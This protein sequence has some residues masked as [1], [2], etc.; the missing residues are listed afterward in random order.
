[1]LVLG[2]VT[3]GVMLADVPSVH[4]VCDD[5]SKPLQA[6]LKFQN[7]P[8]NATFDGTKP[9]NV[10][11]Q[12]SNCSGGP[13][14]TTQGFSSTDFFRRLYATGPSGSSIINK[15]EET[16]HID[17]LSNF[18][19]LS[20]QG[21]L[22]SPSIAVVPVET[23]AGPPSPFFRQYLIDLRTFYDLSVPGHYSVKAQFDALSFD[24]NS[25]AYFSDCDQFPGTTLVT[26]ADVTGRNAFTVVSNTLEFLI[27][28]QLDHLVLTPAISAIASGGSEFYTA[29]GFDAQNHSLGDLT[30]STTFTIAPEGTC[31]GQTCTATA[32]GPHT[33]TGTN[34]GRK[35]TASLTVG[36]PADLVKVW[37]GLATSDDIGIKFDLQAI[38]R[39]A[40]TPVAS[41][42]VGSVKG[43]STLFNN[44]VLSTIPL[45]APSGSL[46][47]ESGD[48]LEV[49]ARIACSGS[50]KITG[51]ARLWYNGKKIDSGTARDAGSR[52]DD[53]SGSTLYF[54]RLN[55]LLSTSQGT[56]RT[57]VDVALSSKCGQ[58]Q[59]FG[60]WSVP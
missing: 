46:T 1:M 43:G 3:L 37:V 2:A 22:Q 48:T 30:S 4:A 20:R 19:C 40:G 52:I 50:G 41:G 21:V 8:A 16:L 13:V 58:Y 28:G 51:R 45:L 56:S 15:S 31:T 9:I 17:N 34:A 27:Q 35:G 59:S 47:L 5:P 49:L 25:G 12:V 14:A 23:L 33:V 29:Q 24:V 26:V 57:F 10:I 38:V 7:A 44:A 18:F 53:P 39:H 60:I 55:S 11:L 32:E 42:Q 54:L 6:T 36:A